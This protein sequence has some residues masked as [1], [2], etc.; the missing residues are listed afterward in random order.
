V[1]PADHVINSSCSF[2]THSSP[3][4]RASYFHD[5]AML[6][7][8]TS[9]NL[10]IVLRGFYKAITQPHFPACLQ[11]TYEVKK[12]IKYKFAA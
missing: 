2:Q 10:C 7:T 11:Q 12:G 8:Y 5:R 6:A 4:R 1:S 3:T 9:N